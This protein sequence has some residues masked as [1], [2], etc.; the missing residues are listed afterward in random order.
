MIG[1]ESGFVKVIFG[2][3]APWQTDVVPLMTAVGSGRTV[4]I[5]EAD[6]DGPPHPFAVTFIVANPLNAGS[7]VTVPAAPVPAIEFPDPVTLQI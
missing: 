4:T 6:A 7:Q 3:A 2:D 5:V 1:K